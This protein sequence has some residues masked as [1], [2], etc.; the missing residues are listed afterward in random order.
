MGHLELVVKIL[1]LMTMTIS[2]VFFSF[3]V[4]TEYHNLGKLQRG[5]FLAPSVAPKWRSHIWQWPS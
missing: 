1:E 3:L 4:L 5:L 2:Q